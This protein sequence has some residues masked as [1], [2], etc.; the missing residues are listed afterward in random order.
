MTNAS[1]TSAAALARR[2]EREAGLSAD[3]YPAQVTRRAIAAKAVE[4]NPSSQL[5]IGSAR[6]RWY[7][8]DRQRHLPRRHWRPPCT[9]SG[10]TLRSQP[11]R[12][13]C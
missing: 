10:P 7:S 11:P 3:R 9:D 5:T 6:I 4:T 1:L 12:L 8:H 13:A 2:E